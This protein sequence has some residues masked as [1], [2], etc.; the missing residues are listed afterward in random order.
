MMKDLAHV[1]VALLQLPRCRNVNAF[2][3]CSPLQS[4]KLFVG[5]YHILLLQPFELL[6]LSCEV[7]P[8]HHRHDESSH[9]QRN[10]DSQRDNVVWPIVCPV[11]KWRPNTRRVANGIDEGIRSCALRWWS[12]QGV[13]DPGIAG[14]VLGEDEDHEEE[15]EVAG[16]EV[17]RCH[18]YDKAND[19]NRDRIDEEPKAIANSVRGK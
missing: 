4:A 8:Q 10:T 15:G 6:V 17:V 1:A 11:C 13:G 19:G 5:Q 12:R 3:F 7:E 18:E 14:S 2:K 16:P 9:L